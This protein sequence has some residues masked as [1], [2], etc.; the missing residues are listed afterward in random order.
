MKHTFQYDHYYRYQEIA[1]IV[2]GYAEKYPQYTR[3]DV[4]GTTPEGRDIL[5][6]EITDTATGD[7]SDKPAYYV[8]GNIHAGEVTGSMT[9]MYLMDTIFSNLEEEEISRL[10]KRYTFYLLPRVS[11]DGAEY[12]LTT[13]ESVRSVSRFYPYEREMPGLQPRDMDGD[14]AVRCMR[15]KSPYGAW[16]VSSL[17]PRLMTRRRPDE[18]D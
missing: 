16:K 9:V 13:P 10:L 4:L 17:D 3:L 6:L 7:F 1:G 8:E 11:P 5:L 14:G 15:V 18:I 12:Y 2:R